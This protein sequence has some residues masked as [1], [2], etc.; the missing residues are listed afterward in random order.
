MENRLARIED[1]IDQVIVEQAAQHVT[2]Q[3]HTKRS[4]ML[5]EEMKPIRRHVAQVQGAIK[6]L[7]LLGVI[8]GIIGAIFMAIK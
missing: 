4:T 6:L 1:K 8:A 3:E 5:E 7:S 2:L